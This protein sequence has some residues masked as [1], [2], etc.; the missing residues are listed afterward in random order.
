VNPTT[1]DEDVEERA[2]RALRE[3]D[4]PKCR[5]PERPVPIIGGSDELAPAVAEA[6]PKAQAFWSRFL[7]L[8]APVAGTAS[9]SVAQIDLGTRQVALDL[10]LI[11]KK[12]LCNCLEGILAHEVGHHVRYPGT[13]AVHARMRMLERSLLPLKQYT[14]TNLFTDLMIN[15]ALRPQFEEQLCR[16]YQSFVSDYN[17][18]ADPA[19]I[20]YL[21]VYEERWGREPG[22]LM[23]AK[24]EA[25]FAKAYPSYRAEAQVLGQNL[26]ALGPNVYTQFLYFVSVVAKYAM[27]KGQGEPV[28]ADPYSC[29]CGEPSPDDWADALTPDAREREA[30]TRARDAGWISKQTAERMSD[31]QASDRRVA[32]LPGFGDADATRVPEVMAAY[33]R[34][35]AERYFLH[36]PPQL[37]TGEATTPTT[38]EEWELGD[39]TRDIDWGATLLQRGEL[40]GAAQPLKRQKVAEAEG[41][42]VPLWQPR[43]EIY[44]D[45]SGSMPDPRVTRNA[46]TLAAQVLVTGAIRAGGWAR[47]TLYSSAPV[48]YR[49]WCRS[50]AELSKFLMHYIGAGTDFPFHL[51]RESVGQCGHD[52]PIRVVITDHDFDVN[53]KSRK[54]NVS[55]VAEAVARSPHF[56]LMLHAA[57]PSWTEEYKS[58]GARVIAVKELNDYP[59]MAVALSNALFER[60]DRVAH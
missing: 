5:V 26:F 29:G 48:Q 13:L 24:C 28:P 27:L 36:P 7:L 60:T 16:V 9:G 31:D 3:P 8:G 11:R 20:F 6:W 55:I 56:V 23:G 44:L 52:Q 42:E 14:L 22:S 54:E 47:A 53:Y 19:F 4:G 39:A 25:E 45:V 46:M 21:A 59:A 57:D 38:I 43:V 12:G 15:D 58:T 10:H 34:Q 50:E 49:E 1:D 2:I 40:L 30:I 51:L 41:W 33:Y 18:R 32:A 35:Q 37:R 17:W